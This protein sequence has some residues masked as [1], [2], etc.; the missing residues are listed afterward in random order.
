V[1]NDLE[2]ELRAA[3]EESTSWL[4]PRADL[5]DVVRRATRHRRVSL[6]AGSSLVAVM[7]AISVL[8]ATEHRGQDQ[9]GSPPG[10]GTPTIRIPVSAGVDA[11]A[12]AGSMLYIASGDTPSVDA[13]LTVYDR[14]TARALHSVLVPARPQAIAVGRDG[15]VWLTFYPD[16]NGGSPGVW[17][18]SPDLRR[19]S[20]LDLNTPGYKGAT[21]LDVLPTRDNRAVLATEFG[22]VSIEIPPPGR[23]GRASFTLQAAQPPS[24]TPTELA[25]LGGK[26]AVRQSSDGG[27]AHPQ[28]TVA[29]EPG[30]AFDAGA[31]SQ[32]TS[33]A[34]SPEGLWVTTK[35]SKDRNSLVLLNDQLGQVEPGEIVDDAALGAPEGVWASGHTVWLATS[36]AQTSLVCFVFVRDHQIITPI[37]D[38]ETPRLLAATNGQVFVTD[39]GGVSGYSVPAACR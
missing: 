30:R 37:K 23:P 15:S 38:V 25:S 28:I 1:R 6:A 21:P 29:G 32:I 24:A 26:I 10:D 12:V 35:S 16:Q 27:S 9:P 8:V 3:F 33:M 18:M 7:L 2:S 20:A 14:K 31:G 19:H 5:G 13:A 4:V 34:A 17:R 36:G 22:L 39:K 11:I